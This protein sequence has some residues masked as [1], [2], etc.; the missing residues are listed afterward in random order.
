MSKGNVL[1][2]EIKKTI[3][4]KLSIRNK[5]PIDSPVEYDEKQTKFLEQFKKK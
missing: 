1:K 4:Y 3:L 5:K 2:Q